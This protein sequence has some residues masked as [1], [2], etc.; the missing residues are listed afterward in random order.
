MNKLSLAQF[1]VVALLVPVCTA[2]SEPNL[3]PAPQV[4]PSAQGREP[5]GSVM[6]AGTVHTPRGVAVPGAAVRLL[7]VTSGRAW[8]TSTNDEGKFTARD[9]PAGHYRIEARQLG[10]GTAVWENDI[11]NSSPGTGSPSVQIELTLRRKTS[12][13]QSA[14]AGIAV[15][16]NATKPANNTKA[17]TN[18]A[19]SSQ[20]QH[21][22]FAS[23]QSDSATKKNGK[24]K[25]DGFEQ[26]EPTGLLTANSDPGQQVGTSSPPAVSANTQSVSADSYLISGAVGRGSTAG[27]TEA[28]GQDDSVGPD[29]TSSK[30]SKRHHSHSSHSKSKQGFTHAGPGDN[31]AGGVVDLAVREK[32]KH[33]GSNQVHVT[34]YNYYDTLAIRLLRARRLADHAAVLSEL[35]R[36]L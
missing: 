4:G 32:I 8:N 29:D 31:L 3:V 28:N 1:F 12:V 15:N 9:L 17:V 7:D 36:P 24:S 26:V 18:P 5:A 6:I 13:G 34:L 14:N 25:T 16:R 10:L 22:D 35:W 30:S 21:S 27:A 11:S 20:S 23:D 33:L 2:A 19:G